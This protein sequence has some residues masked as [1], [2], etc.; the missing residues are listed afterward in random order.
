[1]AMAKTDILWRNVDGTTAI[2]LM[3]GTTFIG[4]GALPNIGP[5]TLWAVAGTG[6]FNGDGKSDILWQNADGTPA[7]WFMN[8][9]TF[10][11][12]GTAGPPLPEWHVAGTGDF[13]GDG[14]ADILWQTD[15]ERTLSLWL[16][17]G[18]NFIGGGAVPDPDRPGTWSEPVATST[19][20]AR[21]TFSGETATTARRR[22]G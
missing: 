18:T 16:M 5:S 20:T 22:F 21:P 11:G 15:D 1:M 19:V 4:G 9:S 10:I 17:N 6:D 13:N 2:W 7:I 8:G 12:G 3:N 14:H